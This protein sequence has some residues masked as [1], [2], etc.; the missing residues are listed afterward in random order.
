MSKRNKRRR[1]CVTRR[2]PE[3][4]QGSLFPPGP[5]A[6]PR[7]APEPV[8]DFLCPRPETIFVGEAPLRR[9]LEDNG[10]G[11]VIRLRAELEAQRHGG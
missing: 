3:T 11:W 5:T 4:Q 6:A 2:L 8:A 9:Y 7:G 1:K 10:M